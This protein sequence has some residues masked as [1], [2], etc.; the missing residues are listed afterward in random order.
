MACNGSPELSVHHPFLLI[1][2]KWSAADGGCYYVWFKGK[3]LGT[4]VA[5]FSFILLW[6]QTSTDFQPTLYQEPG[7]DKHSSRPVQICLLL[8]LSDPWSPSFYFFIILFLSQSY[9]SVSLS[10]WVSVFLSLILYLRMSLCMSLCLS[11][12]AFFLFFLSLSLYLYLSVSFSHF[13]LFMSFFLFLCISVSV[14]L[15]LL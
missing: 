2:R 1:P 6:S 11:V 8:H 4:V 15:L 3:G 9:L 10:L 7:E 14:S 5:S 12:S 13:T